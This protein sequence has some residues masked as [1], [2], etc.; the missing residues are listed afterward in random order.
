MS[1]EREEVEVAG[2]APF[3][4]KRK[5]KRGEKNKKKVAGAALDVLT[6]VEHAHVLCG[7]LLLI[8]LRFLY[9]FNF[10]SLRCAAASSSRYSFVSLFFPLLN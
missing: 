6:K 4:K 9:F 3:F 2:A 7:R 10:F 8:L 5:K 1:A